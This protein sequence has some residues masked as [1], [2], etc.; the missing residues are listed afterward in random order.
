MLIS[1]SNISNLL[2][3]GQFPIFSFFTAIF[4]TIA[5]VKV[6]IIRDFYTLASVLIN[7]QGEIGKK[8]FLYFSLIGGG[9]GGKKT[10]MHV[11]LY[12]LEC[13][14]WECRCA[15]IKFQ[16]CCSSMTPKCSTQKKSPKYHVIRR[17]QINFIFKFAAF[18]IIFDAVT[19]SGMYFFEIVAILEG[20]ASPF[21]QN[22]NLLHEA[23][24]QTQCFSSFQ[25]ADN[26]MLRS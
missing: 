21:Q 8:Q 2:L 25:Q 13:R 24:R 3:S 16:R 20:L 6:K 4:V 5:T 22:M 26:G 9:G 17:S 18:V 12:F 15:F 10:F 11:A 14:L 7:L 19:S 1:L 23:S